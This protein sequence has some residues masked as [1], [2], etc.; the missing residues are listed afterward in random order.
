MSKLLT[1]NIYINEEFKAT[2]DIHCYTL[3]RKRTS[4]KDTLK[5]PKTGWKTIGYY[6]KLEHMV[7]SILNIYTLEKIFEKEEHTL[8]EL[9]EIIKQ[10]TREVKELFKS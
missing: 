10:S 1:S 3:Y 5:K 2:V 9:N 4:K 8:I 7:A 6:G